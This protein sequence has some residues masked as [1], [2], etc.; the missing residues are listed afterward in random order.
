MLRISLLITCLII[1]ATLAAA[2]IRRDRDPAATAQ[3]QQ[4]PIGKSS[5]G[6][7]SD[8]LR[9]LLRITKIEKAQA[10]EILKQTEGKLGK[11]WNSLCQYEKVVAVS[12]TDCWEELDYRIASNFA[13]SND[14]EFAGISL[15]KKE[16]WAA[17]HS[18]IYSFLVDLGERDFSQ[19]NE[20]TEEVKTLG[21]FPVTID[22]ENRKI[23]PLFG[24]HQ[25]ENL[26][27]SDRRP[28]K[29][30]H[31][32][33]L[34]TVVYRASSVFT[35]NARLTIKRILE[36][37]HSFQVVKDQDNVTTILWKKIASKQTAVK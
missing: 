18:A 17:N 2:Q 31:T 8:K 16:F 24:I 7:T 37:T 6:E 13:F 32:Y 26:E 3:Q 34:R 33:L 21:K 10:K 30:N 25:F 5:R 14:S 35:E 27:I 1:S 9:D 11:I 22:P 23:K 4:R 20:E 29:L 15:V 28:A 19:I 36:N 12:D